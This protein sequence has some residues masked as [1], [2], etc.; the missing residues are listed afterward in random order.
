M[1]TNMKRKAFTLALVAA[2]A[3][4]LL[5]NAGQITY[6]YAEVVPLRDERDHFESRYNGVQKA[7]ND[8]LNDEMRQMGILPEGM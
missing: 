8:R 6:Y 2:L 5:G 4:S 7:L 1:E 3:M